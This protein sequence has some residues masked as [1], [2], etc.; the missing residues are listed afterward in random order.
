MGFFISLSALAS[1]I[2]Q[3][4]TIHRWN[5]IK[6]AQWENVVANVGRPELN[7][8]GASTGLDLVVF[9][10]RALHPLSPK[11]TATTFLNVYRI[12]HV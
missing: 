5:D 9:Y 10:I 1:I 4:H 11:T 2:Q 3:A 12:L 7:I 8:T 6:T